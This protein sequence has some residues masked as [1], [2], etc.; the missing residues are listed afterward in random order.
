MTKDKSNSNNGL[1]IIVSSSPQ[2]A[3]QS[4]SELNLAVNA[5]IIKRL[6][7]DDELLF[8]MIK[9]NLKDS[10][11]ESKHLAEGFIELLKQTKK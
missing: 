8:T 11:I 1:D 3:I 6:D 2:K 4:F 5:A 10:S 9:G 7:I